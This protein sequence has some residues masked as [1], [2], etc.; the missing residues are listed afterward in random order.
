M[1]LYVY[2]L[3]TSIDLWTDDLI[4]FKI[5]KRN[6]RVRK[7]GRENGIWRLIMFMMHL[8]MCQ[9]VKSVSIMHVDAWGDGGVL[10]LKFI[11]LYKKIKILG[12]NIIFNIKPSP[13]PILNQ[14]IWTS[15]HV[16]LITSIVSFIH[17]IYTPLR[18]HQ[19][20][21]L[22]YMNT[23]KYESSPMGHSRN[24]FSIHHHTHILNIWCRGWKND[25]VA[26]ILYS[27]LRNRE[28]MIKLIN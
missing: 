28:I 17:K 3:K 16:M 7:W 18:T 26:T 13:S 19:R 14:F 1:K 22:H 23:S 21:Y 24:A 25:R 10:T 4:H 15:A 20:D 2:T 11:F 5:I 12:K 27:F 8:G 6:V 9:A